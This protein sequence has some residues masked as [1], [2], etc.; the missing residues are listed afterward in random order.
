MKKSFA[1]FTALFFIFASCDILRNSPYEVTAWTPGEGFHQDPRNISVSL[2]FSHSSDRIK[3]EQAFSLT[4]NGRSVK[5]SFS[6][7]D[8]RLFFIPHAPLEQNRDYLI[9]LGTGAQ[10]KQGLSL[11]KKFQAPFST[12]PPGK[13]PHV[14]STEPGH[15]GIVSERR[16]R[17][18]IRFSEPVLTGSCVQHISINPSVGG[19]WHLEDEGSLACFDPLEPWKTGLRYRVNVA[20]AFSSVTDREMGEDFSFTFRTSIQ[21]DSEKPV[22]VSAWA[23]N[24]NDDPAELMADDIYGSGITEY[25]DWESFTRLRLDFSR[26]VDPGSVRNKLITEPQASLVMETPPGPA[27]SVVFR[28]AE[29]PAWK[30]RFLFRLN[31]G[32]Q[33]ETGNETET[34]AIFRIYVGGPLSKPP[35]LMGLRLPLAPGKPDPEDQEP[36]VFTPGDLFEDL[37]LVPGPENYPYAIPVPIWLELYFDTVPDIKVDPFSLMSLFRVETSNDVVSFT[38]RSVRDSDFSCEEPVPGWE[39]YQRV[40]IRGQLTNKVNSGVVTF[41]VGAGLADRQGNLNTDAARILLLK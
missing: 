20:S 25:G 4:E 30:T 32:V 33:D 13:R 19:S 37:P 28:F 22:L 12:R 10:D 27:K 1:V 21:G 16:G 11:E 40:E 18:E 14:V 15:E 2:L 17:I 8:R 29:K 35:S 36:C 31:P 7:D 39:S 26:A 5:G 9:S 34:E 23:L 6:W 3:T 41:L 38:P 24:Q